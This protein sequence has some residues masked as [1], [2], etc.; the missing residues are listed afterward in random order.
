MFDGFEVTLLSPTYWRRIVQPVAPHRSLAARVIDPSNVSSAELLHRIRAEY[1]EMPGLQLTAPQAQR[2]FGVDSKTWDAAL[3]TL[4][5]AKFLCRTRN[6]QFG[7]VG[8]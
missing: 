4:V 1:R 8:V 6:G 3:A 5:D 7:L 2:L